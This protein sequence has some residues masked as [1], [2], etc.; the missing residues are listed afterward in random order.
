MA[1][2]TTG[3]IPGVGVTPFAN[4]SIWFTNQNAYV[5]G[6]TTNYSTVAVPGYAELAGLFDEVKIDAIEMTINPTNDAN[7]Y[8]GSGSGVIV[9]A[10]DYNDHTVPS[11]TGDVQ[12]YADCRTIPM[13]VN[14]SYK[15][16]VRPKMLTYTLDSAGQ[17]IAST[18]TSGFFRSNL[19]ID[20]NAIKGSFL[21]SPPGAGFYIFTFRYKYVCKTQK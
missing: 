14:H 13:T 9:L 3:F 19:D 21:I 4:F 1:V 12:Q 11:A 7:L 17:A 16:V 18:P 15:C 2:N 8:G 20:H 5:W 10:N 6:G